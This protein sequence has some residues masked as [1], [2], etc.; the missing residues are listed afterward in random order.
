MHF[1]YPQRILRVFCVY[2]QHQRRVLFEGCVG[3]PLQT[4]DAILP[5]TKWSVLVLR[6]VMQDAMS[7][8]WKV[9]LAPEITS[10]FLRQ[11]SS[12][13]RNKSRRSAHSA[14]GGK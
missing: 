2:F 3:D 8:V 11:K 14:E 4:P 1:F 9:Y 13:L 6:N 5:S 7:E 12:C 10:I